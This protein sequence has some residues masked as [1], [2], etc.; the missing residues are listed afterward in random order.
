MNLLVVGGGGREHTIIKKLKQNPA[1]ETI[2]ALPG[3]GGIAA[4]A[5]CVD[6]KATDIEGI[7]AFTRNTKID[8]AV[9]AP[10]DPLV[11]GCVDA[12][13][14]EGIPCFGP[15]ANAAIIEG[16]KVFSKD[17]MKKY[18]IPTAAPAGKHGRPYGRSWKTRNSERAAIRSLLRSTS[19]VRKF[20][21]WRSP[22][23]RL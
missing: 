8:Y 9:V 2:Y 23:E 10:D 4:D 14:A 1:V 19:K 5:T 12:L 20:L 6:I 21:F 15:R 3:N 13:E 22:T 17:L 18:G 11:L 16:S 7:V